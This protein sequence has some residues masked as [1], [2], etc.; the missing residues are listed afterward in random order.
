MNKNFKN[1]LIFYI[2]FFSVYFL[3][4]MPFKLNAEPKSFS[5][6]YLDSITEDEEGG[7]IT[8]PP[9]VFAEPVRNEIYVISKGM[10]IVYT[11]DFFPVFTLSKRNG[12]ES[13][14]G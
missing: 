6:T 11:S 2:F 1:F 8:F 5:V 10:I 7:S 13:P 12:I 3:V 9:F 14:Q 4:F